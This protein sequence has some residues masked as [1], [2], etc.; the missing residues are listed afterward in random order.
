MA[1]ESRVWAVGRANAQD[2]QS[3]KRPWGLWGVGLKVKEQ[4]GPRH[5]PQPSLRG[6]GPH[7]G[8]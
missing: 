3:W 1:V 8:A 6:R 7:L 2:P 5:A 4:K